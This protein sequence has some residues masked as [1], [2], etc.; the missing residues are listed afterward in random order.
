MTII[1]LEFDPCIDYTWS[2]TCSYLLPSIG[3]STN[4]ESFLSGTKTA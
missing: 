2:E 3:Y 4:I 1:A